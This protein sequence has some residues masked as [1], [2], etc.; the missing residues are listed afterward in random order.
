MD[1]YAANPHVQLAPGDFLLGEYSADGMA[2]SGRVDDLRAWHRT[3]LAEA[4]TLLSQAQTERR[5]LTDGE[6]RRL[7]TLNRELAG[8]SERIGRAIEG[9]SRLAADSRTFHSMRDGGYSSPE[10][11]ATLQG[12]GSCEMSWSPLVQYVSAR[13]RGWRADTASYSVRDYLTANVATVPTLVYEEVLMRAV[14][15]SGVLQAGPRLFET[16]AGYDLRVPLVTGYGTAQ[17]TPEGSAIGESQDTYSSVTFDSYA[18]ASLVQASNELLTDS[19]VNLAQFVAEGLGIQVGTRVAGF[20]TTGTGTNQPQGIT[21]AIGTGVAGT[22]IAPKV[23]DIVSLY[24][25]LPTMYRSNASWVMASNTWRD[26]IKENDTTGRSLVLGSVSGTDPMQLFGRPVYLD[27]TMPA[28]GT[29]NASVVFADF[30]RFYGVRVAGPLR[31]E[32]S[33]DFAFNQDL[34]T[35]RAIY[36]LDGRVLDSNAGKAFYGG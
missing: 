24:S 10:W 19:S 33:R 2:R 31:I 22:A 15:T 21:A 1:N 12:R 14:Q 17:I 23:A 34:T 25:S 3:K 5:D 13:G 32:G 6:E 35:W 4:D 27:D 16:D 28:N 8:I 26:L 29:A 9:R 11:Q 30:S 36:R 7:D 20:L 18:F